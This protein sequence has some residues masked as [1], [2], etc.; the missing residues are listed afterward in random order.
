M[1]ARPHSGLPVADPGTRRRDLVMIGGDPVSQYPSFKEDAKRSHIG[2]YNRMIGGF[3]EYLKDEDYQYVS[4]KATEIKSLDS[5]ELQEIKRFV[6]PP[7]LPV[8]TPLTTF[9]YYANIQTKKLFSKEEPVPPHCYSFNNEKVAQE[10][11]RSCIIGPKSKVVFVEVNEWGDR[12]PKEAINGSDES[13]QLDLLQTF[14]PELKKPMSQLKSQIADLHKRANNR[15]AARDP[16]T[17]ERIE[18]THEAMKKFHDTLYDAW[19]TYRHKLFNATDATTLDEKQGYLRSFKDKVDAAYG[20]LPHHTIDKHRDAWA[21][22]ALSVINTLYYLIKGLTIVGAA[23]T[24]AKTGCFFLP[25][26]E[27]PKTAS[28]RKIDGICDAL[29]TFYKTEAGRDVPSGRRGPGFK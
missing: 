12:Q 10:L 5:K 17:Q 19:I 16:D 14:N 7:N 15:T 2:I 22:S 1:Y 3:R 18:K 11:V 6:T 8:T 28:R 27:Q 4:S 25:P 13:Y 23:H 9:V 24:Y 20:N 29:N 21:I 26:F